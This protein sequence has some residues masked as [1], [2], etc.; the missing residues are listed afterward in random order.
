MTNIVLPSFLICLTRFRSLALF[1]SVTYCSRSVSSK[2]SRKDVAMMS[3]FL[4]PYMVVMLALQSRMLR[5]FRSRTKIGFGIVSKMV[6]YFS[7]DFLTSFSKNF[8]LVTSR[9]ISMA[10]TT[11]PSEFV[12]GD[13][14]TIQKERVPSLLVPVSSLVRGC[15]SSKVSTT[16]QISQRSDRPL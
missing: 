10:A 4:K 7:S 2:R 8:I 13:V 16:G 1:S 5:V 6:R 15:P 9:D 14:L 12:I 3:S 11:L